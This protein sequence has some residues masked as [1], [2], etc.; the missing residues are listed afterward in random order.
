MKQKRH[1]L[2]ILPGNI[3][4][5]YTKPEVVK[6]VDNWLH[7]FGKDKVGINSRSYMWHVFSFERYPNIAGVLAQTEYEKHVAAEYIVLSNDR[8]LAFFTD[9]R[10]SVCSLRDYLVFPPNLAWTMAITHEDGWLG[11][12]FARHA[13]YEKLNAENLAKLRKN[14]QIEYARQQGWQ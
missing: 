11:P 3:T 13:L 12:Y 5:I 7:V 4:R 14:F 9:Q 6:L 2:Q 8:D 10:P 1:E